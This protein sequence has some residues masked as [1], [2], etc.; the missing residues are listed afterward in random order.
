MAFGLGGT[1]KRAAIHTTLQRV[2]DA[3]GDP[4]ERDHRIATAWRIGASAQELHDA[5]GL[6]GDELRSIIVAQGEDPNGRRRG[7]RRR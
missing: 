6:S 3:S 7:W 1:E 4:A 5:T 2:S